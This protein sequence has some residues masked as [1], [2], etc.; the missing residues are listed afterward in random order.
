MRI[1]SCLV[2][3]YTGHVDGESFREAYQEITNSPSFGPGFNELCILEPDT[4]VDMTLEDLRAVAQMFAAIN[5]GRREKALYVNVLPHGVP[6]WNI[7]LYEGVAALEG[8]GAIVKTVRTLDG[9]L[10][11]LTLEESRAEIDATLAELRLSLAA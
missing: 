7:R 3:V 5:T 8:P 1:A 11:E 6:H 2:F 10:F 4:I 9:G